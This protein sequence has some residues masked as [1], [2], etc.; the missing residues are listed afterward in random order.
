V[1]VTSA[2]VIVG[3][4]VVQTFDVP[5][6]PMTTG[7]EP[8]TK[9][10]AA[11]RTVRL[12]AEVR[13]DVGATQMPTWVLATARGTRTLDDILPFMPIQPFAITNPI[14]IRQ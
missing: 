6:R 10:E 8:G 14:F 11:A 4:R 13:I 12:D 9:E 2:N 1:D 7:P 3:G 5:T